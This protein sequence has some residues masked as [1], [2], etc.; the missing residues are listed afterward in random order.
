MNRRLRLIQS[1]APGFQ[2][3]TISAITHDTD[4]QPMVQI[5]VRETARFQS[6]L[7]VIYARGHQPGFIPLGEDVRNPLRADTNLRVCLSSLDGSI[8]FSDSGKGSLPKKGSV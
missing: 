7:C 5:A 1:W 2:K 3:Q 4:R 6:D 8:E